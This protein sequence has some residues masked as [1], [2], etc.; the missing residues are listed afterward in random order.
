MSPEPDATSA[1]PEDADRMTKAVSEGIEKV[2]AVF[3]TVVHQVVEAFG[4]LANAFIKAFNNLQ[5]G[6][7]AE[8]V[9][10]CLLKPG[11]THDHLSAK[12]NGVKPWKN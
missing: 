8:G 4:E 6:T 7:S 2:A 3:G 9:G 1:L 10:P 5:C 11:H 12:G